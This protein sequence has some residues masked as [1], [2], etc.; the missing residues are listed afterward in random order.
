LAIFVLPAIFLI[1]HLFFVPCNDMR[2]AAYAVMWCPCV[3]EN[4]AN[5]I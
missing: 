3:C 5:F 4:C 2:T 1:E